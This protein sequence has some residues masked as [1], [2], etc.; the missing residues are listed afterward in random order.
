MNAAYMLNSVVHDTAWIHGHFHT[1]VGSAAALSFIGAMYW[2]VPRITG[3]EL[4]FR[5][6]FAAGSRS[7]G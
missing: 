5:R 2:L 6:T 4:S 1:T 3:R 7:S